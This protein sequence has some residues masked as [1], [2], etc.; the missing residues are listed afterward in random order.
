VALAASVACS[1]ASEGKGEARPLAATRPVVVLISLDGVRHDHPDRGEL[2]GLERM[3]REGARALALVPVFPSNTFPNHVA[4]ATG[5]YADRHGIVGNR[6]YDPELGEFSY[7]NDARFLDAEPL[8]VAAERQGVRA[9]AFFWVGSETDWRGAGA[10]YRKTPF[11]GRIGS[12]E[13]TEQILAW[14]D[15]PEPERP[16]LILSW[17]HGADHMGHRYGPDAPAT[18]RQLR[19][20]DRELLRL[21]EGLDA[22]GAF[23]FTTLLVVSDHGMTHV[24]EALD[25][26]AVL[27]EVGIRARVILGGAYAHAHLEDPR[28]S[29]KAVAALS[30]VPGLR[31]MTSQDLPSALRYGHPTRVGHVVALT[32]PPRML[33]RAAGRATTWS[34]LPAAAAGVVGAHGYDPAVHPEMHG[35]LLAWG[36]GVSPGAR[37]GRVHATDV[38]PTVA[39]LLEIEPP[40]DAEG[41]PISG[42]GEATPGTETASAAGARP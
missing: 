16:G 29:E 33:S 28:D 31:A 12:R 5:T 36:R 22:R 27:A 38:A 42:L 41:T 13:K 18:L 10:T 3:M 8:W 15:L 40:A 4:L 19:G 34:P 17:W 23:S 26:G 9:A 6:F 30:A 2:P 21:I 39:R 32:D 1:I 20:Q 37:L 14:L 24:T 11:D 35:I 7:S 25:P